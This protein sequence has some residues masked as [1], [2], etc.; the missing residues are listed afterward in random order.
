MSDAMQAE[1]ITIAGNDGDEIEA[2]LARRAPSPATPRRRPGRRAVCPTH[3]AW[4]TW[5]APSPT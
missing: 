2:Y 3:S 1:T 5:R 4:A